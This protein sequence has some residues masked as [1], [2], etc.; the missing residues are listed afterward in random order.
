MTVQLTMIRHGR[1]VWNAQG[2]LQGHGPVPLAELGERQARTLAKAL[3]AT[4]S[5]TAL[6]SSDVL[7]CRQTVAPLAQALGM[8][9]QYDERFRSFDFGLWQGFTPGE[10][11]D[12]D[13][14]AWEAHHADPYHVSA[15]GGENLGMMQ[16]RV[17]DGLLDIVQAHPD[18][19]VVL[20]THSGP[21]GQ[22]M[23]YFDLWPPSTGKK[24]YG[25]SRT[26]I[27]ITGG[28][29]EAMQATLADYLDVSH[30]PP[31]LIA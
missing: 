21:I 2:R 31:D 4:D 6:Y 15:P 30:L 13:P 19:N 1:S 28:Q 7:R 11:R 29:E 5:Y 14:V 22:V 23:D 27:H 24:M 25:T 18:D 26:V 3:T 8:D 17:L 16:A 9:V 20:V 12:C 10:L